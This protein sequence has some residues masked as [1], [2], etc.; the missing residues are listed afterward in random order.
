M[1]SDINWGDFRSLEKSV[2]TPVVQNTYKLCRYRKCI[3]GHVPMHA[4]FAVIY[5]SY[6]S[7]LGTSMTPDKD[8]KIEKLFSFLLV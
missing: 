1:Q 5:F 8:Q 6:L 3:R 2:V 7:Y 4:I